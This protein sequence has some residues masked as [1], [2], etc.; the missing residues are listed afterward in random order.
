MENTNFCLYMDLQIVAINQHKWI[1]SEK[2]GYDL[3]QQAVYDWINRE[4]KNF[5][6]RYGGLLD[7]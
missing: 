2:V 7:E 3:G 4:A 5:Y 1:M 6:N